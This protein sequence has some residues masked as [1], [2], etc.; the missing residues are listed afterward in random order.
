LYGWHLTADLSRSQQW[1]Q[2]INLNFLYTLLSDHYGLK[3]V[4]LQDAPR[5]FVAETYIVNIGD[6]RYFA[7]IVPSH[8]AANL[9]GSLPV[10]PHLRNAGV[11]NITSPIATQNGNFSVH[12]DDKVLLL[13]NYIDGFSTFDYDFECY[14]DLI[15]SVHA[16]KVDVPLKAETFG[17]PFQDRLF[18]HLTRLW[19]RG[20]SDPH[21][22]ELQTLMLQC[23]AE[24]LNDYARFEAIAAD[25]RRLDLECVLTHGDP[26]G[27]ILMTGEGE[28]YLI[29]WD[30]LLLAPRERDTWFHLDD[31]GG[32][33]H[34]SNSHAFLAHYRKTFPTYEVNWQVYDYYL[35]LRYFDDL[36]GFTANI[37]SDTQTD[38]QK[39]WN[40]KMLRKDWLGWLRTLV[41]WRYS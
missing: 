27:N 12:F 14:V 2:E 26:S 5:G 41:R 21:Q 24:I 18:E 37:L 39:A 8:Y 6:T 29:D 38:E 15:A 28:L 32:G 3:D 1:Q 31:I 34:E 9:D 36:Y 30:D 17:I 16:A 11:E 33:S 4:V 7:K 10:L 40:M 35:H 23:R 22:S 25:V 20:F 19:G 13:F